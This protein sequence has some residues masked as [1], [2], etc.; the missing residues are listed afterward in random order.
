M[1]SSDSF[2]ALVSLII[3]IAIIY[4][5]GAPKQII[6]ALDR[7]TERIRD[8]LAEARKTREEAQLLLAE[9]QRKR[10]DAEKEA[11]S[12]VEEARQEAKRLTEEA[13]EK[14]SEMVERRTKAAEN[15]IA[16]AEAQAVSEVRTK[17][18]NLAVAAAT[19]LLERKLGD[20]KA[21]KDMMAR[22]IDTVKDR[23]H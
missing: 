5:V 11:E 19:Q 16:Q 8:E 22:S 6:A 9:Y 7:R 21:G 23:L 2:W 12:I 14:L 3:F 13:N 18:T 17:A 10:L 1:F 20:T 15:K 4:A